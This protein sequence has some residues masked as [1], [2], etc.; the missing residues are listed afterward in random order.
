MRKINIINY[1]RF[2]LVF[3]L[4]GFF[5]LAHGDTAFEYTLFES[6]QVRPIALSANGKTLFVLNTPDSRLEIFKVQAR[7]KN[8]KSRFNL[9][10]IASVVVGLE[11]VALAV[12]SNNEVW[13]VNHLSD[14]VSVVKLNGPS[15]PFVAQTL[16]V[17]DEPRD[18]VFAGKKKNR[19]FITTAHRG[20]NHPLDP[21]LTTP[22]VGRADVWVYDTRSVNKGV[23]DP[24]NIITL[25]T[26]TPRAL[27]VSPDGAKVYAAGFKTGNQTTSIYE[28]LVSE[29]DFPGT[30][31]DA[32]GEEQPKTGLI[33]KYNGEHWVDENDKVWDDIVN[34]NLPDKDVFVIDANANPP[35]IVAG[36]AGFYPGVG[37]VLFNMIANPVTGT[38]YVTN[39]ESLNHRR[40][41]GPGIR[42]GRE[43]TLQGNFIRNRISILKDK[44]VMTRHLNNHIDYQQ[45]CAPNPNEENALSIAQ[46][47]GMAISKNGKA[48]YV[49]GY[50]SQKIVIYDTQELEDDSFQ[51]SL[52][53]QIKLSGGGPSGLV[54]NKEENLLFVLTR[55]DNAVA[56]IDIED[57]KEVAKSYL[58]NPEPDSV[59]EGRSYLYDASYTSSH[60]DASCASC[61]IF[62]DMDALAWDL[63]NPDAVS[64]NNPGPFHVP[65]IV[66]PTSPNFRALKGPM[67]TQ[68]LRG[69]ANHGPMNWRG[70]RTGGNDEPSSQPDSGIFNEQLAFKKANANFVDVN[71]R[72]EP[73][74]DTQLQA[75]TDFVLQLT[76][77]PNPIRHLDNSLTPSQTAGQAIYFGEVADG[78]SNCNGCHTLDR[79]ANKEF[80]V[81]KPGIFGSS[82]LYTFAGN[83]QFMKVAHFR[84]VYQKVGMF[85][86][87]KTGGTSPIDFVDGDNEFMGDQIRGFGL[88]HDGSADTIFRLMR[89]YATTYRNPGNPGGFPFAPNG[90]PNAEE[91]N[92]LGDTM[93]RNIEQFL[94][95]FDSNL[96]PIVGQQITL[97]LPSTD[98]QQQRLN[99]LMARAKEGECDLVGFQGK[100]SYRYL[101][102]LEAFHNENNKASRLSDLSQLS[103]PFTPVTFLCAPLGSGVRLTSS[104]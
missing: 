72:S 102:H 62:G 31:V 28:V 67:T 43:N 26:D 11:P 99:L 53:N 23:V 4:S 94:L 41:K 37:T 40:F 39:T 74:T 48:L 95:A 80:D 81:A 34:F 98:F 82:G 45:C 66:T 8:K 38:V 65:P 33:V 90:T 70:D 58:Y 20:Q 5:G 92:A 55:F 71:G 56:V 76:Y 91:I 12:R 18:I 61:H 69:L 14:S 77:P 83:S 54:I 88:L 68:S 47:L 50:G 21:E 73:L 30:R 59:V 104:R 22:G 32:A 29:E 97:T 52:D 51:P 25:F 101:P 93:R 89:S 78:F 84:N 79:N 100:K 63:G 16:L 85:G 9:K 64:L 17:G 46:P 96:A 2:S 49:A 6:G 27:T 15:G 75:L 35:Q 44:K 87:S 1:A 13:V 103:L 36:D 86:L 19:A 3:L 24:L 10:P 42:L 60:G 57:K 7:Q